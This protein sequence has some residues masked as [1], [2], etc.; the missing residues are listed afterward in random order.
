MNLTPL[1][2]GGAWMIEPDP[3]HDDRG[4]FVRLF[5]AERFAAHGL[6]TAFSYA[7]A[8][9]NR[10]RGTVRGLH[11]QRPP[12]EEAKLVRCTAG[13]VWDVIVDINPRSVTRG[14]WSA[15][16]LSAENRRALFI[17]RGFA[18][19][20]QTLTPDA[21]LLYQIVG[22]YEPGATAGIR[23][24]DPTLAI[25]WPLPVAALSERDNSLPRID[26][27]FADVDPVPSGRPNRVGSP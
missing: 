14:R 11:Y 10:T 26:G 9:W 5:E 18:H 22:H 4:A 15:W 20:F 25:P 1:P 17:P 19:G 12:Y 13:A 16:E 7:A 23:W 27:A 21:E 3:C 8:S 24:D 2:L 6:P